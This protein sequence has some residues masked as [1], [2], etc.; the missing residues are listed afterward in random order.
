MSRTASATSIPA[1]LFTGTSREC[2][3]VL[4]LFRHRIDT[5]QLN[6]LVDGSGNARIADFGLAKVTQNLDSI[7]S[8]PAQ[9]GHTVRWTAPELLNEGTYSKETDIF[10]FAMVMIEVRHGQSIPHGLWPTGISCYYR[11]S[12]AQ[13]R[14]AAVLLS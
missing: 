8:A 13:S 1:M 11:Y 10:S 9:H 5:S 2:V 3:A 4:S 6:I 7:R 12:L 14:L